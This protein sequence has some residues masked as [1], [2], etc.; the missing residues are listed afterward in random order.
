MKINKTAIEWTNYTANP[1]KG[2]CKKGCPYCYAIRISKRFK[3]NLEIRFQPEV[4]D[5]L[6][7]I[8]PS[9]VF[10]CST[11]ELFGDWI[12]SDWIQKILDICRSNSQHTFQ[13]LTKEP[14]R[15]P[16]FHFSDNIWVGT[17]VTDVDSLIN[18]NSL[19]RCD[20]R[21]KFIS[22]EP[23]LEDVFP[24]NDFLLPTLRFVNWIIIGA[25]TG[26]GRKK[27]FPDLKWVRN[28]I[29]VARA[30]KLPV[31][32]KDNLLTLNKKPT[33][34]SKIQEFPTCEFCAYWE[35][36]CSWLI[37]SKDVKGTCDFFPSRFVVKCEAS[38]SKEED[39]DNWRKWREAHANK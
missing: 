11:H 1:I 28:I 12:P 31:F 34:L 17:T 3:R 38:V 22:F 39:W 4:L 2:L 19:I 37:Q 30:Y 16:N 8:P 24:E 27:H 13:I 36:K 26:P 29:R 5:D 14:T 33:G 35:P 21:V 23:L 6:S 7:K 18:V 20:A 9:K 25:M 15:L 10:L 32:I